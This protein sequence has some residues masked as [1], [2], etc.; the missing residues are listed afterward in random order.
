MAMLGERWSGI[1]PKVAL[2][3]AKR[4]GLPIVKFN[5]RSLGVRLSDILK[6]EQEA[7][8]APHQYRK[9][10]GFEI[11]D[12]SNSS[13]TAERRVASRRHGETK[14]LNTAPILDSRTST[15][16]NRIVAVKYALAPSVCVGSFG[17]SPEG[18]VM[19][20]K[21]AKPTGDVVE[22]NFSPRDCY[23][24]EYRAIYRGRS[25]FEG[26]QYEALAWWTI[27]KASGAFLVRLPKKEVKP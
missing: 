25:I 16:L 23:G 27:R 3:R 12:R 14:N 22:F 21:A 17:P 15:N 24:H 26:S 11:M 10:Q 7:T 8:V 6:A 5:A 19:A 18:V 20:R 9:K 1:H 13:G 4:L 2:Q